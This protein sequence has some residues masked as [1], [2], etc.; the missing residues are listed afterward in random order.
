MPKIKKIEASGQAVKPRKK[1][2][3]YARVSKATDQLMHSLS[4]QISYYSNLIQK[5]PEWEYAGVYADAGITGTS[6]DARKEFQR[7]IADCDAGKID[8]VLTKSISRFARNTVDLLDTVRHLKEI[9]VEVRF[10]REN[11]NS[12][13]GDG[14]LMLSILASFAQEE[15]RSLSQNIKW[16][17]KK[18][19]ENG[20]VHTHQ[21]MLGYRWRGDDLVIKEDEA[22]VVRRIYRDYIDGK[23]IGG[24]QRE[25]AAE[26]FI[27]LRGKPI[28]T[29]GI[30]RVLTNEEYTGCMLFHR[31]YTYAPKKEKYNHGEKAMYRIDDHHEPI[32]TAETFELVQKFR[33][34]RRK[35]NTQRSKECACFLGKVICGECGYR[36]APHTAYNRGNRKKRYTFVCNNRHA[37]G[38]DACDNPWYAKSKLDASCA[39][40]LG[41]DDYV[42]KFTAEIREL[43]IYKDHLEFEFKDGR[44]VKWQK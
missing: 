42:E 28:S 15:S 7:L 8:I 3:A 2:A 13:S 19:Y 5:N 4:A 29:P 41:Q 9:G 18:K 26:G 32:I 31:Q 16:V 22:E 1:V 34:E 23:T 44:K 14:E 11:I 43:R 36:M 27:G 38:A 39:E 12:M 20:I 10:E 17:V 6:V 40:V 35:K 37:N 24:I 21:N 30:I 25:L 33:T